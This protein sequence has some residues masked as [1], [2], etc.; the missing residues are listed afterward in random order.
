MTVALISITPL[1]TAGE[2]ELV[3]LGT[4]LGTLGFFGKEVEP[5]DR[6]LE[7]YFLKM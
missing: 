7:Y 1:V 5:G 3:E 2:D 6:R 4:I